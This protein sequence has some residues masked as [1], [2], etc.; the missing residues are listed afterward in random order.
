MDDPL[1]HVP[2]VPEHDATP[3]ASPY[4]M[5]KIEAT[6][7]YKEKITLGFE[8]MKDCLHQQEGAVCVDNAMSDIQAA[9][10]HAKEEG[11]SPEEFRDRTISHFCHHIFPSLF[12]PPPPYEVGI[13]LFRYILLAAQMHLSK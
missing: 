11:L 13:L 7:A 5:D 6:F 4:D 8:P 9:S 1:E 12:P 2:P 10:E 3:R